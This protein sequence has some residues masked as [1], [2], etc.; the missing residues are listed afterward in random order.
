MSSQGAA[1][2]PQL[3]FAIIVI[4]IALTVHACR[5]KPK[6]R[7][8]D[9]RFIKSHLKSCFPKIADRP[10]CLHRDGGN[11]VLHLF[12]YIGKKYFACFNILE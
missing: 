3:I 8:R 7:Q 11:N 12:L 10:I 1:L 6:C 2:S 9:I 5:T 4:Q